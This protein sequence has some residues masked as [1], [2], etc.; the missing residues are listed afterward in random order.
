MS[1]R[2]VMASSMPCMTQLRRPLAWPDSQRSAALVSPVMAAGMR[3]RTL[4]LRMVAAGA[5]PMIW[6]VP[7]P[8]A[9]AAREAAQVPW[10]CWS[11]GEP[12]SQVVG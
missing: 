9:A 6:P 5:T 7:G 10:P 2:L 12:S 4:M 8:M 1:A 3:W 11:C